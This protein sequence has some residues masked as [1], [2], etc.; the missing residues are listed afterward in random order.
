MTRNIILG[1]G[2]MDEETRRRDM[3]T[4]ITL[5]QQI[6]CV[7][8]EIAFRMR[9]YPRWV[10]KKSMKQEAADHELAAMQAV[11]DTLVRLKDG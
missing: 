8:R 5:D 1:N 11:H 9:C 7:R 3:A 4:R 10:E 2:R 6:A